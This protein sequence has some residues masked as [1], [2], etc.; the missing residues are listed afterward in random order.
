MVAKLV[1]HS[2]R[3][4]ELEGSAPLHHSFTPLNHMFTLFK[5]SALAKGLRAGPVHFVQTTS[6]FHVAHSFTPSLFHSITLSLT[7]HGCG[8]HH[9]GSRRWGAAPDTRGSCPCTGLW[10]IR[11][12]VPMPM[13]GYMVGPCTVLG[14]HVPIHSLGLGAS[15]AAQA[16]V[17]AC[18]RAA[19]SPMHPCTPCAC[20]CR[21]QRF[22]SW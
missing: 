5:S 17:H 7:G 4:Q 19:C 13:H 11:G 10:R 1:E 2:C 15:A 16:S 20:A 12:Q 8:H 21:Q 3:D 14:E 9:C 6:H 18:P 22:L